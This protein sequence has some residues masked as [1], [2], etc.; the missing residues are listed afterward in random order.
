MGFFKRNKKEN[1][2]PVIDT[3]ETAADEDAKRLKT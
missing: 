1:A 2:E 3:A